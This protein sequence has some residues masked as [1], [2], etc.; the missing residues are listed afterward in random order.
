L[1]ENQ[2]VRLLVRGYI[3]CGSE[4]GSVWLVK[5]DATSLTHVVLVQVTGADY[6]A[7]VTYVHTS[8]WRTV[9]LVRA[10]CVPERQAVPQVVHSAPIPECLRLRTPIVETIRDVVASREYIR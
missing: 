5:D 9:H 1:L 10:L 4:A 3:G 7:A 2:V 8:V 6:V